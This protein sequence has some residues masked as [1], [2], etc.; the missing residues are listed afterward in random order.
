MKQPTV[1]S[2]AIHIVKFYSLSKQ[3]WVHQLP[4][5]REVCSLESNTRFVVVVRAYAHLQQS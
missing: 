2:P 3:K 5:Q 1:S 4:F